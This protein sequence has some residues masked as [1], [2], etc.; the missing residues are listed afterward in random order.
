MLLKEKEIEFLIYEI[1]SLLSKLRNKHWSEFVLPTLHGDFSEVDKD[2]DH[3]KTASDNREWLFIGTRNLYYKICLF[4]ELKHVQYYM[5]M[6]VSEFKPIIDKRE[7]VLKEYEGRYS[8]SEP[9]MLIL[10]RFSDF[11]G[12]FV[13]F[14]KGPIA[15]LIDKLENILENT[16]TIISMTQTKI[17]GEKSIYKSVRSV[18]ELV[19]PTT[20]ALN[21]SRFIQKYA[22]YRPDILIPELNTAIEYKYIRSGSKYESYLTQ[23][24][25]D[26][27]NYVKDPEY[28]YFIAVIYFEDKNVINRKSF[29][30]AVLE[31]GFPDNWKI[32]FC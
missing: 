11:L 4:L 1:D 3:D 29:N 20:R 21:K 6:F 31:K 12:S 2:L 5:Q 15:L 14:N 32:I 22:T 26:A 16:R 8:E 30:E 10:D 17:R 18:V 28:K 25:T 9:R 24:K 13:E 23:I 27:D 19:F 7:E